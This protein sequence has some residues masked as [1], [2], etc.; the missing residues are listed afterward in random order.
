MRRHAA[1]ALAAAAAALLLTL[2][3]AAPVVRAPSER[4]FGAAIV[5]RHHDPFTVMQQFA[6]PMSL[7]PYS[8][9][10]TDLTGAAI[11]RVT[12]AV[13]A[14]NWLVLLS[15]PLSAAAAYLLARHLALPRGGA[16]FAALLFAFSPF[17]VAQAA[18]HPHVAQ[19]Q[20]LPLYLLALWRCMDEATWSAVAFLTVAVA[21]VTL[22]NFYGGLIAAVITPIAIGA[23]WFARARRGPR[24]LRQVGVT[25]GALAGLAAGGLAWVGWAAPAVVSDRAA[26]AFARN[27]LFT[28]SAKWWS[29]LVPPVAHPLLGGVARRIWTASRVHDGLL[30]QQVSLGWSVIVLG[31]IAIYAWGSDRAKADAGVAPTAGTWP[32]HSARSWSARRSVVPMLA[33]VAAGALVCSLSP[34]RTMFGVMVTRPSALLY[35]L[36]PMFRAYARFGVIVQLMAALLAGIGVAR[37]LA[38]RTAP[39]RALCAGLAVLAVAEY[40]VWPPTLWRD[41]LPTTAHR[42]VVQQTA[43]SRVFDCAPL[44]PESSSVPWLTGGRIAL[45]D[46]TDDDC[47]DPQLAA[48]LWA[49]GF[50]HILVRDTWQRQW[51]RDHGDAQGLHL[52]ARFDAA[53]VLSVKPRELVYTKAMTG[54]SPREH[55]DGATWRWMGADASWTIVTPT[56]RPRVTLE[57]D[58]HAFHVTRPLVVR[59]DGRDAQT[60]DVGRDARIYRIGPLALSAG[61]HLLTFHSAAPA[62][63]ADEVIGNGDRRAL[64]FSM[65]AWK[66]SVE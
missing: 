25:A 2:V 40:A 57:V 51:L 5:G 59:L 63:M 42:W 16:L 11:A 46:S 30:E 47:A 49:T 55:G 3:I 10:V 15:F 64:S 41:V 54:F 37:L 58:L 66:W 21:A 45:A 62:T 6:R 28:F 4:I 27:D 26:F 12:G 20:W 61:P 60:L 56:P 31:S 52:Q 14:Y 1:E 22:S 24:A 53:D 29:Y 8:Q 33:A 34:E 23:Y 38:F 43:G 48:K 50:T 39:A 18:Y 65:G 44:T 7:G 32:P 19:T 9:P 35:P 17:H 13:A 36:V